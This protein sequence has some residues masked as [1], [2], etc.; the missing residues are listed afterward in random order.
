MS[1][2]VAMTRAGTNDGAS[3]HL[4]PPHPSSGA[5]EADV[6]LDSGEPWGAGTHG[7]HRVRE[8]DSDSALVRWCWCKLA[9][10]L[11]LGAR[12][13]AAGLVVWVS[14]V[15]IIGRDMVGNMAV[16]QDGISL[17]LALG[18]QYSW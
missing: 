4:Q 12:M 15:M 2:R 13:A 6:V 16:C 5:V 18:Q 10:Q 3:S 11:P 1:V 9:S 8:R 17:G 14:G 7:R